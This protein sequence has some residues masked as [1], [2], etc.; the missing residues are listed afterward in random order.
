MI[1]I[2]QIAKRLAAASA[3]PWIV[4]RLPG[5]RPSE[6][7]IQAPRALPTHPYDIELL[8]EDD[9]L[10]PT[11]AADLEFVAHSRE[12]VEALIVEVEKLRR[13]RTGLLLEIAKLD[14][15]APR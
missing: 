8:G 3:G 4:R 1:D 6:G 9:T 15:E 7:F 12:D 13:E 5:S 14:P 10:Y 2:E 11:R